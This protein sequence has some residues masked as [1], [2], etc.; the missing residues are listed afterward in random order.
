MSFEELHINPDILK[1][2]QRLGF[3]EPTAIQKSCI[4]EI[5]EG[6]DVVGQSLT[7]SGKTAAFGI[8]L[9]EKIIPGKHIQALILTPTRELAIQVK[10]NLT[11]LSLFTKTEITA[12][13]GGVGMQP[14]IDAL[15]RVD[16]VVATPGRMLDHIQ[17]NNANLDKVHTLVL[18]EADKMFEMGFI[19]DVEEI[20]QH[21][22]PERQTLLFSATMPAGVNNLIQKHLQNPCTITE[23]THVDKMLLKQ[24]YYE[25]RPEEKFSLLLYFLKNKT[26]GLAIVFCATRDRVDVLTKNLKMQHIKTLAVH[27]GLSQNKRTYAV[28]ALK[29][30]DIQVLVATDVAARGLDISNISHVYNYDSPKSANEYT[31]RIGRTARAGKSGE[32]VTLLSEKDHDNFRNVMADPDT[33]IQKA[34]LPQ[35]ERIPFIRN[36]HPG[37][38][39]F[40]QRRFG[41]RNHF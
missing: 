14:Q 2:V 17:R 3:V 36:M 31:H 7:G 11:S 16:V 18:D 28:D 37:G 22:P 35:F 20:I 29:N 40:S 41:R 10:D 33:T 34:E 1:A 5:K 27:G 24:V 32:A 9:I 19:E 15:Q 38:R 8:P 6:K 23:Q 30:E 26:P 12:V 4:P 25:V 21:I 39:Q 13:Y